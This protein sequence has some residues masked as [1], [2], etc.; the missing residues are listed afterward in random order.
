MTKNGLSKFLDVPEVFILIDEG[1][2]SASEIL[3]A[4]L[5]EHAKA[6]LI[7]EKTF[8]KGTVQDARD[9]PDGSGVHITTAKWLTPSGAW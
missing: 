2:A 5:K 3:A 1:S 6:T 7:G 4:A 9:F 8:G